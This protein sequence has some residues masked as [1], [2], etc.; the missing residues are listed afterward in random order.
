MLELYLKIGHD[1]SL[2]IIVLYIIPTIAFWLTK[3]FNDL[4][5]NETDLT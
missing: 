1:H 5:M 4:R 2:S 3:S